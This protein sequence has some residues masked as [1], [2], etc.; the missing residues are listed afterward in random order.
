MTRSA[1]PPTTN[2]L[3]PVLPSNGGRGSDGYYTDQLPTVPL[4]GNQQHEL[5]DE[6]SDYPSGQYPEIV[7]SDT[8]NIRD[9]T[10]KLGH[11]EH[12]D[13]SSYVSSNTQDPFEMENYDPIDD[14]TASLAVD[15][16]KQ[17]A[18]ELA[19]SGGR[20]PPALASDYPEQYQ[21]SIQ[22]A[23][24][25]EERQKLEH[26]RQLLERERHAYRMAANSR[27][28]SEYSVRSNLRRSK[29][30]KERRRLELE[31]EQKKAALRRVCLVV[32][33]SIILAV[34]VTFCWY[35]NLI[36]T[37][38]LI[39]CIVAIAIFCLIGSFGIS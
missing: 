13:I 3:T 4:G 8:T 25:N 22:V 37:P 26:E 17:M 38:I 14:Q 15:L 16:R 31:E 12:K 27:A 28:P 21:R 33:V 20:F 19:E 1:T 36:T 7:G 11:F 2:P 29:R 10:S 23:M 24:V 35:S 6:P 5:Y 18:D 9:M 30:R 39:G 34:I 32:I